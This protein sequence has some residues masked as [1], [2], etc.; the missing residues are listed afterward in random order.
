MK[1]AIGGVTVGAAPRKKECADDGEGSDP[2]E[3]SISNE[4]HLV[5][6]LSVAARARDRATSALREIDPRA[7]D[8]N[9]E[10]TVGG[11]RAL[12]TDDDACGVRYAGSEDTAPEKRSARP[13]VN[14]LPCDTSSA[15]ALETP[16]K[17]APIMAITAPTAFF[18]DPT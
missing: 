7:G 6:G 12:G 8:G 16:M 13:D 14:G 2:L 18:A 15:L 4:Q 9:E 10:R 17:E 1:V 3:D 11:V 5:Q